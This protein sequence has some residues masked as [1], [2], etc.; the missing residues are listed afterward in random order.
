MGTVRGKLQSNE[1]ASLALSLLFFVICAAI[2]SAIITA[3]TASAGRMKNITTGDQNRYNVKSA[4]NLLKAELTQGSYQITY[5]IENG[6]IIS[7]VD[8]DYNKDISTLADV[9]NR[10][11]RQVLED[12]RV[13]TYLLR[14]LP[15]GGQGTGGSG[16]DILPKSRFSPEAFQ[17]TT[18]SCYRTLSFDD[19]GVD[20]DSD[21]AGP[22]KAR[23]SMQS[24]CTMTVK[25]STSKDTVDWGKE[26]QIDVK[27]VITPFVKVR[28]QSVLAGNLAGGSA[29]NLTGGSTETVDQI[30]VKVTWSE[31]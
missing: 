11:A 22:A 7:A 13:Q 6:K 10:I 29:D 25:V 28:Y 8:S 24:D 15:S 1:G 31:N 16:T 19:G 14:L 18:N 20:L 5:T 3:A 9:R 12:E 30:I 26:D 4:V 17:N 2:G 23:I 21:T 27:E